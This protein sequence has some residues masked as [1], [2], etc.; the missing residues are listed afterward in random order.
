[1]NVNGTNGINGSVGAPTVGGL[2]APSNMT[3]SARGQHNRAVSLPVFSQGPFSQPPNQGQLGAQQ[4]LQ[5][6]FGSLASGLGG[7]GGNAYGM[8]MQGEQT[9]QGWAEE[10]VQ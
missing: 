10:E 1:L 3:S 8:S 5:N 2:L 4:Q 7:F 6:N 9:L